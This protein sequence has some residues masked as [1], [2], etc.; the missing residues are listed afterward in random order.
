MSYGSDVT[1]AL[2]RAA[3]YASDERKDQALRILRGE[4]P[5]E[6]PKPLSGPLLLG[7]L[8]ASRLLGISR[9]TFWRMMKAGTIKKIEIFPGSF[10][11]SRADLEALAAGRLSKARG[12]QTENA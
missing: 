3:L 6:T 11:V 12:G 1:I 4:I 9:V 10:R 8:E 7:F 2:F 5:Q